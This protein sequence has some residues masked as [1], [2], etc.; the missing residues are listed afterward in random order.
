M[1]FQIEIDMTPDEFRKAFG[2]ADIE[3]FQ[4]E[5]MNSVLEKMHKGEEGYD[6]YTLM[7]PFLTASVSG[8]E[9][10]QKAM[11]G[12]FGQFSNVQPGK[13]DA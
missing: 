13:R 1:K 11:L 2:L 12:M 10:F 8:M 9:N 6:P 5:L 4:R 7:Q 3:A